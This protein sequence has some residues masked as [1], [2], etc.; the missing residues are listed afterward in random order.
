MVRKRKD[1]IPVYIDDFVLRSAITDPYQVRIARKFGLVF[2]AGAI[3][4]KTKFMPWT[5][6]FVYDVVHGLMRRAF[7]SVVHELT[8]SRAV[9]A[10]RAA[11]Q[12]KGKLPMLKSRSLHLASG[13][14]VGFRYRKSGR[15]MIAIRRERLPTLMGLTESSETIISMLVKAGAIETGHGGKTTQQV[16]FTLVTARGRENKS[17]R[18][19]VVDATKLSPSLTSL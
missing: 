8:P 14:I 9:A 16:P 17:L 2:A 7:E 1:K 10:L 6:D 12:G 3:A 19:V 4:A 5:V 18:M 11:V 15:K 13:S